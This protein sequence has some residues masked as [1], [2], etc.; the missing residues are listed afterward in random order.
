MEYNVLL[1]DGDSEWWT[2]MKAKNLDHLYDLID[3]DGYDVVKMRDGQSYDYRDV[4]D[5]PPEGCDYGIGG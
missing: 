2:T 4:D 1:S 3:L 5:I